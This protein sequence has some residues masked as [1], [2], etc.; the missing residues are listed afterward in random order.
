MKKDIEELMLKNQ[1][2]IEKHDLEQK[3]KS[4]KDDYNNLK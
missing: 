4:L 3:Y 2:E 1:L